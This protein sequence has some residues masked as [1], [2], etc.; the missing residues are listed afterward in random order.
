[1]ISVIVP[2][3][4]GETVIGEC[5]DGLLA[6]DFEGQ[7]EIIVVDDGSTDGT[8][9]IAEEKGVKVIRQEH[10]GPAT[11]RNTGIKNARGEIVLFTDADCVPERNWIR[12]M[13]RPFEDREIAGVQ[14]AY[15]TKQLSLIAR[16][17]Q[18]E[19]EDRYRRMKGAIDF[20]GTYAAGYRKT[21]LGKG[22]DETFSTASGEDSELSYRLS[23]DHR[24][25]FHPG[26]VVYHRHPESLGKYL[27][28]KFFRAA[29][30]VPLYKKHSG[31]ML[32][33]S[34]TPQSL[35]GQIGIFYLLIASLIMAAVW[36]QMI[37]FSGLL[38]G[39]FLLLMIP[40]FVFSVRKDATVGVAG[41]VILQ[42]RAAVFSAGLV[43]GMVRRRG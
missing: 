21:V 17:C 35:K 34:Y 11:A 10:M 13:T 23:K 31:K 33:D 12:E 2:V 7:R 28:T 37:A 6:Q 20:I 41:L 36:P 38:Y 9:K 14:G 8:T 1:M 27:R 39:I 16:F 40:F 25:V 5:I 43:W 42:L 24:L 26:A 15:K 4:N 32:N 19:I 22:F 30:R 18:L 3:Y 29:W